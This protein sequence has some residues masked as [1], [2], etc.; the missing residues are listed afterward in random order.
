MKTA[1][2]NKHVTSADLDGDGD[3]DLVVANEQTEDIAVLR[4]QGQGPLFAEVRY[5]IHGRPGAV[6]AV[7][8]DLDE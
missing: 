4:N 6:L 7:D 2:G 3:E 8:L 1:E 5:G